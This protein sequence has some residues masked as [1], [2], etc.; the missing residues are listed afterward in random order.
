MES[1][2]RSLIPIAIVCVVLGAGFRLWHLDGQTFS[3]DETV[4]AQHVAGYVE[5]DVLNALGDARP[6]HAKEAERFV[7]PTGERGTRS[8]VAALAREDPQ[9]P[10][11]FYVLERWWL[12]PAGPSIAAERALSAIFGLLGIAAT[13]WL[14]ALAGRSAVAGWAGAAVFALSPFEVVYAQQLREY[15]LFATLTMASAALLI[16]ALRAP[17]WWTIV[18]L[19][20]AVAAGLYTFS[21]FVLV[22]AAEATIVVILRPARRT[23]LVV[24]AAFAAALVAWSPWM[25]VLARGRDLV[26]STNDWSGT[27]WSPLA[28][29]AKWLYNAAISSFDL[30]YLNAR[31]APLAAIV[32]LI[33][34]IAL[35]ETRRASAEAR[36]IV[37]ALLAWTFGALA[38]TDLIAGG[39]RSTV[40]RYT[41]PAYCALIVAV[42]VWVSTGWRGDGKRF[43]FRSACA[44]LL[45]VLGAA[46]LGTRATRTVWW[47]N[48]KESGIRPIAATIDEAKLPV[49]VT[50]GNWPLLVN[51]SRYVRTNP[52]LTLVSADRV[53]TLVTAHGRALVVTTSAASR[54]TVIAARSVRTRVVTDAARSADAVSLFRSRLAS[55]RADKAD[56]VDDSHAAVLEVAG[57]T[58]RPPG[59]LT[60]DLGPSLIATGAGTVGR[61]YVR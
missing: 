4:A 35:W 16:L 37:W 5:Q 61:I 57:R 40:A 59:H 38:L 10:P 27:R 21:L 36:A 11:L 22:V 20:I 41:T 50:D 3:S 46:S 33:V 32:L 13:W 52:T 47:D 30:I 42:A 44:L 51:L 17:R 24:A 1:R 55:A 23:A 26:T 31:W 48:A 9:H 29:I 49:L 53:A 14:C 12:A 25:V 56:D 34:G 2:R 6:V 28:L 58:E 39:H 18:A 45:C 8:V 19:A 60:R 54:R 43:A 15:A 7:V